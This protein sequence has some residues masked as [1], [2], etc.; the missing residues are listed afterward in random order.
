MT[1]GA[2]NLSYNLY[3]DSAHTLIW[4]D[5]TGGS[6]F[7]TGT[8]V[9]S[10][11]PSVHIVINVYGVVP[12]QTT[13]AQGAYSDTIVATLACTSGG[14]C[15][16]ATSFAVTASVQPTCTLSATNLPF[17][18]YAWT[19]LDGQSQISVTCGNTT[20]WNIGLNQGTFSGATVTTRRMTG[21][22]S[23]SLLYF[24][25]QDAARTTNW[26]DTVGT[27]TVSGTG[28]GS[29]QLLNVYGRVPGSQTTG[30]PGSYADTI[31]V[32]LTY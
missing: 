22:G 3:S 21:P 12:A 18:T 2:N 32:T 27:D 8:I 6:T 28:T 7:A 14:N 15:S 26:G 1:S 25:Y 13:P 31:L 17:G 5:G 19:Q 20:P 4:G 24:L 9:L 23:S 29:A 11:P 16:T 30:M 10:P